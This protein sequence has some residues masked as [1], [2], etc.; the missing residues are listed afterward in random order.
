MAGQTPL[1]ALAPFHCPPSASLCSKMTGSKPCALSHRAATR[2]AGPPPMMATW[3][4]AAVVM[5]ELLQNGVGRHYETVR[6][7][8]LTAASILVGE[9]RPPYGF[10]MTPDPIYRASAS[11]AIVLRSM[12][13]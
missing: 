8:G 12:I 2:P 10:V 3:F 6:G 11:P 13:S 9:T 4:D 5:G 1:C 7:S